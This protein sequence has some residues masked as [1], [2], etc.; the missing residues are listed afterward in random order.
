MNIFLASFFSRSYKKLIRKNLQL[1]IKIKKRISLFREQPEHPS[2]KLHKLT[3]SFHETWSF[4]VEDDIRILF[5]YA[6]GGVILV[7][8]G[9]HE[10][11]Y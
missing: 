7:D 3:G 1:K 8:I 9:K 11:V 2:L 4:S 10:E 6:Q 5:T